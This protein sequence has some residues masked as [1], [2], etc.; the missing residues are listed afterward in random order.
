VNRKR[1]LN[2]LRILISVGLIIFVCRNIRLSDTL[3]KSDGTEFTGRLVITG[4]DRF[5]IDTP[6]HGR[7]TLAES[8]LRHTESEGAKHLSGVLRGIIT[9]FRDIKLGWYLPAFLCLGVV[10]TIGALRFRLLLGVQDIALGIGRVF[11]LTFIGNFF[12]NFMLGLTGGDLVK[13][14]YVARETHKRTEAVITV[15]LDRVVGLVGLAI[16]AAAMVAVNFGD[17]K[18]RT[19]AVYVWLF[20]A[21]ACLLI[22]VL[23]SRRL[24]R[25]MHY[26]LL[27][28]AGVCVACLLAGRGWTRGWQAV[29][30]EVFLFLAAAAAFA[31]F[32]LFG[33]VRR[34]HLERLR[35]RLARIKIV[36]ETDQT[37]HVFSRRPWR[38]VAALLMSFVSHFATIVA[39]FGLARSLGIEVSFR[40]FLVF[41]PVIVM[42][43]AIPVS[44]AGW[45]VQEAVFQMFFGSVGVSATEAITL[46]FVYRLS[47]GLLWSLPGGVVLM[48]R[49]DR[50]SAQEVEKAMN[51][52]QAAT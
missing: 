47:Y 34:L 49:K 25:N 1:L 35:Q 2:L 16:L 19:T 41:V 45:G 31:L 21:M 26:T 14:Y 48:L 7:V 17:A 51:E 5:V 37:F 39:I 23:Y 10:P 18:F 4:P 36:R 3:V 6:N 46:S 40:Y 52:G 9:V 38:S 32:A 13:A 22:L 12:N 42:I 24:R 15:F 27:A 30:H 43:A 11:Q 33:G 8:E 29:S 44:M 20:L 28:A 50:A